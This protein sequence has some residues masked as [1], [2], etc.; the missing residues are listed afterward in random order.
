MRIKRSLTFVALAGAVLLAGAFQAPVA[1]AGSISYEV[2]VDTSSFAGTT[3]GLQFTLIAGNT[4]APLDTATITAF[5]SDGSLFTPPTTSGDVMGEL[6]ATI[7][8]D[9]QN[10]SLYFQ[11][12]T[13]GNIFD[14]VVTLTSTAG[15]MTSADTTFSFYL[16]DASGNPITGANSPSGEA[17]DI[18]IQGPSG[19]FDPPAVYYPPPPITLIQLNGAVPEPS[20]IVLLGLGLAAIS[21]RS[22]SRRRKPHIGH[23]RDF[24]APR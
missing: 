17:F 2:T 7:S 3:G 4:P 8:M 23:H 15:D 9:N 1:R 14:Y 16:F 18:N 11:S 22:L 5:T 24:P 13:F 10:P 12:I 20:T 6:P 21:L 19:T